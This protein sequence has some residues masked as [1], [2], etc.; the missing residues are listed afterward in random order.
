MS[1]LKENIKCFAR[2]R[3]GVFHSKPN[4]IFSYQT[5]GWWI[6]SIHKKCIKMVIFLGTV[7][8]C[9]LAK[10]DNMGRIVHGRAAS[11][12]HDGTVFFGGC[13]LEHGWKKWLSINIGNFI[14]TDF[15]CIIF[16]GRYTN[17]QRK[18]WRRYLENHH[19]TR[20][21][22]FQH[23]LVTLGGLSP[24]AGCHFYGWEF[25]AF[26]A[27]H[28]NDASLSAWSFHWLIVCH[29]WSMG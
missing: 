23:G 26:P 17:H 18:T 22:F 4:A 2:I 27:F 10:M 8:P 25:P 28:G 20:R 12:L 24:A 14:I 9:S 3:Q 16:L 21:M 5:W 13:W 6:F 1:N 15:H 19:S 11:A 7:N 29:T